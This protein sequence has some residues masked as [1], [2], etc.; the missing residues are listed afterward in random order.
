MTWSAKEIT[1]VITPMTGNAKKITNVLLPNTHREGTED[2]HRIHINCNPE[3][4]TDV[5]LS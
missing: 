4:T 5:A 2:V 1:S 3:K